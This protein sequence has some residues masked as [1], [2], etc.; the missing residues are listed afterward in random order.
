[1]SR[2]FGVVLLCLAS[3]GL[4][5]CGGGGSF[6]KLAAGKSSPLAVTS[7]ALAGGTVGQSYAASLTA[8]G[9]KPPYQWAIVQG[10]LPVGLTLAASGAVTGTPQAA[11]SGSL[12]VQVTDSSGAQAS[13]AVTFA[14]AATAGSGG[15]AV[16]D[17]YGGLG[18]VLAPG[19]ATG[20]FRVTKIQTSGGSRWI[21]VDPD[22]HPFWMLGV[23]DVDQGSSPDAAQIEARYGGWQTWGV[24]AARRLVAWGFNTAAEYSNAWVVAVDDTGPRNTTAPIPSVEMLRPAYYALIDQNNYAPQPVK[25][26]MSGL[27]SNYT[28]YT[29]DSLPDVFDPNFATYAQVQVQQQTSTA[30]ADSPWIAGTAVGDLD[31]LYGFG[32]G[33]DLPTSP[34]GQAA[35]NI[36]WLVLCTDFSQTANSKYKETYSDPK[37]YTKY[38]LAAYLQQKYQ[39]IA[40]L[41]SAWGSDYTSFGDAGGF[42]TGTGLLDEDGRHSW[43]GDA[44][45]LAG[46]TTAMQADLNNFLGQYAD[47]Y[48]AITTAAVRKYRPHQLVFGP[49]TMNS[50]GGVTRGPILAAAGKYCDVVQASAATQ[51]V[52]DFTLEHTG[53]KPLVAWTGITAN[54]DSDLASYAHSGDLPTQEARGAAYAQITLQLFSLAGS[55]AAGSLAGSHNFVGEKWWAWSDSE[56]EK[57]NWGL[58]TFL[59]NAYDGKEDVIA[60]GKDQWGYPTGGE[61]GNYG[62]FLTAAEKANAQIQSQLLQ[63]SQ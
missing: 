39:T 35:A 23:F 40:A 4:A 21:F 33:P 7:H 8:T 31:D 27:D 22:G 32:A 24:Q 50:W 26:L 52:Y 55:S 25:D 3:T 63:A 9:G 19:G 34:S 5:A 60:A 13:A 42:G 16:L 12:T 17:Q 14:I 48:F 49:A 44:V 41:N 59:G 36:G 56:A 37:V 1:M 46:E 53:D 18:A 6:T 62:D 20:Y 2:R 15:P 57:A 47:E 38:A 28:G 11:G 43:V 61:A 58:V 30:E 51:S 54:P 10:N 29:G 45:T